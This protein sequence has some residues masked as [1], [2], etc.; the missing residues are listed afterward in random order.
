MDGLLIFRSLKMKK[1][2]GPKDTPHVSILV[3][4]Y[5][6]EK[7]LCRCLD[8][9]VNQTL[10]QIEIICI[11]DGSTDSTLKILQAYQEKDS[12]VKIINKSNTGY[13]DSLNCAINLAKGEYIG[14][15]EP[16]DFVKE[17]MFES[18]YTQASNNSLDI[19]RCPY[20]FFLNGKTTTQS[21]PNVPKNIIFCPIE[22]NSVFFQPPS[23]WANLYKRTWMLKEKIYFL[24]TAGA[25]YQDISFSFKAY[26]NAKRFMM[27]D[28][29]LL[30]YNL[31]NDSSSIHNKE[32]IFCVMEEW[33]E[34]Y[35]VARMNKMEISQIWNILPEIQ[36]GNYLWNLGHLDFSG[37]IKFLKAWHLE[38]KLHNKGKETRLL[39][40]SVIHMLI[41]GLILFCPLIFLLYNKNNVII[42]TLKK[43][44]YE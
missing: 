28:T 24:P 9:I 16:D 12:R 37:K 26:L 15:V 42:K 44:C 20:F 35:R 41:E 29:P 8:S 14:I 34:I 30:Y 40:L 17:I 3:P 10:R 2:M 25:S 33:R 21:C 13:G 22:K 32:K 36:H 6:V 39:S 19:I 43:L 31:G 1:V 11:N 4:C 18:L 38:S 7:Y 27:I 23:V 5:N